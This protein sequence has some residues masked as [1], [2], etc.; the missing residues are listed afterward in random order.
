MG[1]SALSVLITQGIYPRQ[2][3]VGWLVGWCDRVRPASTDARRARTPGQSDI[4]KPNS[5][6]NGLQRHYNMY[7]YLILSYRRT[8]VY[9]T[10]VTAAQQGV[11][12]SFLHAQER[13]QEAKEP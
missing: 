6:I 10:G 13:T 3:V 7:M 2:R 5:F 1:G 11:T 4:N 8:V 12:I 9:S